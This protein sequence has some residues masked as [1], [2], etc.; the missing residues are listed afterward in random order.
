MYCIVEFGGHQREIAVAPS[1]WIVS[2]GN[3]CYW[4]HF[5]KNTTKLLAAIKACVP[6][7]TV[8]WTT[9]DIHIVGGRHFPT[10]DEARRRLKAAE[11]GSEF[12][13]NEQSEHKLRKRQVKQETD[14]DEESSTEH[15]HPPAKKKSKA[16]KEKLAKKILTK[17]PTPPPF[18]NPT[19]TGTP[20]LVA[21]ADL[22]KDLKESE[23][24]SSFADWHLP[25]ARPMGVPAET[26][27]GVYSYNACNN[28]P[29]NADS[30]PTLTN[31]VL[32]QNE[33]QSVFRQRN[34]GNH[35]YNEARFFDP[36]AHQLN[37]MSQSEETANAPQFMMSLDNAMNNGRTSMR[38]GVASHGL[39]MESNHIPQTF[40]SESTR[41]ETH[42]S[43]SGYS[44]PRSRP[45]EPT[46]EVFPL[47]NYG[48][49]SLIQQNQQLMMAKIDLLL[50]LVR[51]N[52]QRNPAEMEKQQTKVK[53]H[54]PFLDVQEFQ[55]FDNL[56][57]NCV[58]TRHE[59]VSILSTKGGNT[60]NQITY[61]IVA[62]L[63]TD[64]LMVHYTFAGHTGKFCFKDTMFI[65]CIC[66]AVRRQPKGSVSSDKEIEK[67]IEYWLKKAN[68]RI[69]KRG[70]KDEKED[71]DDERNNG[72]LDAIP[73]TP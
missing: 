60:S 19:Q 67:A 14:S 35:I 28:Q 65:T 27:P 6:P 46:M 58:E 1:S 63:M 5:W 57:R 61:R 25:F 13:N 16:A 10:Y 36:P 55:S 73:P 33:R 37:G 41:N 51:S 31:S 24:E 43:C 45:I 8:T 69:R 20:K 52:A 44:T 72:D 68:T 23:N 15:V 54:L 12:S 49:I 22:Y 21:V 71:R 30:Y 70:S 7:D 48:A 66:D 11:D 34:A 9:F 64:E 18:S 62:A 32:P 38:S 59:L 4:P 26:N 50:D 2:G 56:L 17:P 47:T 3:N 29:S 53:I 42:R 40:E 39:A